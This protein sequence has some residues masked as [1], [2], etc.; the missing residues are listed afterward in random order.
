MKR[1]SFF[2]DIDRMNKRLHEVTLCSG[3]FSFSK[4]NANGLYNVTLLGF[5]QM[6]TVNYSAIQE[7]GPE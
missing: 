7:T 4:Q 6:W 5:R 2:K 3:K 1:N